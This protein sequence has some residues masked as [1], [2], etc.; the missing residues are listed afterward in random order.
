MPYILAFALTMILAALTL[1]RSSGK[2]DEAWAAEVDLVE[3]SI[4]SSLLL[5]LALAAFAGTF[6]WGNVR[7]VDRGPDV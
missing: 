6:I 5:W 4:Y 3:L 2:P 1:P 7:V